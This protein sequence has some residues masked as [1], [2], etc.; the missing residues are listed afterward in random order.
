MWKDVK[1]ITG[2]GALIFFLHLL[3]CY[4]EK[5]VPE[6][7]AEPTDFASQRCESCVLT[8]NALVVGCHGRARGERSINNN[9]ER[10]THSP[11][12]TGYMSLILFFQWFII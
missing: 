11:R 1:S 2:T 9:K 8:S 3:M 4:I 6:T 10:V 5:G 12:F 7:A